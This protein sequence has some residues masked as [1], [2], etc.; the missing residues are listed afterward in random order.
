M[1]RLQSKWLRSSVAAALMAG[2]WWLA[3]PAQA[4]IVDMT[5]SSNLGGVTIENPVSDVDNIYVYKW[6]SANKILTGGDIDVVDNEEGKYITTHLVVKASDL[7]NMSAVETKAVLNALTGKIFNKLPSQRWK[8]YA[9][10]DV[11]D[12]PTDAKNSLI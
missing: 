5:D 6:D 2:S 7:Q 3:T 11:V 8:L 9:Y 12:D 10:V 1:K 4:A